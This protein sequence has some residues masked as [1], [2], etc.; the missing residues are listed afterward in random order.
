MELTD[1]GRH[2]LITLS[3]EGPIETTPFMG[4]TL[5]TGG[6]RHYKVFKVD[7]KT[8]EALSMKIREIG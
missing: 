1:D 2:W 7:A 5:T 6:D 3:F 4:T 8:G